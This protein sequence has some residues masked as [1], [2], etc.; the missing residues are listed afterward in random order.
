M[1]A[2][3]KLDNGLVAALRAG[4][5]ELPSDLVALGDC[6]RTVGVLLAE[7]ASELEPS[8]DEARAIGAEIATLLEL[9]GAI[10]ERA[11]AVASASAA[12]LRAKIAILKALDAGEPEADAD[13]RRYR[14]IL[15]IGDDLDR[16]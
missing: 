5:C 6:L 7:K 11:C 9:E 12:D 2:L 4:A 13:D 14:L 10:V 1:H 16:F 15:S 3:A 8:W